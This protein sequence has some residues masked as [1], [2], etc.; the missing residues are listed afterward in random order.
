[1]D[2]RRSLHEQLHQRRMQVFARRERAGGGHHDH[3]GRRHIA[4][5][6]HHAAR[7]RHRGEEAVAPRVGL[8]LREL[9]QLDAR[10]LQQHLHQLRLG[11]RDQD[12]GVELAFEQRHHAGR[13]VQ[14]AALDIVALHEV[15]EHDPV[16]DARNTAAAR[17]D[18]DAQAAQLRE[19]ADHAFAVQL[20]RRVGAVKQP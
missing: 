8:G 14:R 4:R 5:Q 11:R 9:K 15:G 10:R 18:V 16:D 19:I 3:V 6:V 20:L 12:D 2:P 7:Q 17:A 1:M 13:Q